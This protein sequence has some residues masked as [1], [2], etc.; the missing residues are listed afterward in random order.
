[1]DEQTTTPP[2]SDRRS[3]DIS[4]LAKALCAAQKEM[5][6]AAKDGNNPHFKSSYATL[7]SVLDAVREPL[8]NN[9]LAVVQL[10]GNDNGRITLETVLC[11]E[12]GQFISS[13]FGL[14]PVK[15]DPQGA[16]S[17][18]TYLRRYAL[19]AVVGI[20]QA[21]DDANA[22][23]AGK[24]TAVNTGKKITRDQAKEL[25]A[26][27]LAAHGVEEHDD[28]TN[29]FAGRVRN[30][31]SIRSLGD[32]PAARF[33]ECMAKITQYADQRARDAHDMPGYRKA[34]GQ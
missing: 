1:M 21:D 24:S 17:C 19:A 4:S 12:S 2:R 26:A 27:I 7:A 32:L 18:L 28:E 29:A 31:Y 10:P 33:D 13:T 34:A 3:D 11:H 20:A 9:G 6:A 22:A 23:S 8:T 30:A 15:N 5:R 16:G 25:N 14:A